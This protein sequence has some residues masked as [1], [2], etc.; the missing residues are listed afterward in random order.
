[1][2]LGNG[3]MMRVLLLVVVVMTVTTIQTQ[4]VLAQ[5]PCLTCFRG[6]EPFTFDVARPGDEEVI[7]CSEVIEISAT[8]Q[9]GTCWLD[10]RNARFLVILRAC[11][12]C[13]LRCSR[14]AYFAFLLL[15]FLPRLSPYRLILLLY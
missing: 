3:N 4:V 13:C 10:S 6:E 1:M 2:R 8:L 15:F 9:A 14:I 7:E 12:C 11:V 5:E